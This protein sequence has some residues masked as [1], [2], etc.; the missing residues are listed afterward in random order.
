M[1]WWGRWQYPVVAVAF[2]ASVVL[3]VLAI[4]G[5]A[6]ITTRGKV[7]ASAAPRASLLVFTYAAASGAFFLLVLANCSLSCG[8]RILAEAKSPN[9]NW[10]AVWYLRQ[11][12]SPA[13]YC[14][15]VS[16]VSILNADEHLPNAE[17]NAFSVA[18]DDGVYLEWKEDNLLRISYPGFFGVDRSLRQEN[19]VGTVR[20]EYFPIGSM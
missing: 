14:P 5:I 7:N 6:V 13:R 19:Q 1:L 4:V 18:A 8:N 12:V 10:K 2:I 11:C 15:P 17:G 9:G 20:I 3:A 16:F